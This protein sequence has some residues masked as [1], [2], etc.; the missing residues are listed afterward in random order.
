MST[1]MPPV[2]VFVCWSEENADW[3][4]SVD[5]ELAV[6]TAG[7][8]LQVESIVQ[9]CLDVPGHGLAEGTHD[10]YRK[11][12]VPVDL[13]AVCGEIRNMWPI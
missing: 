5:Y 9:A 1:S 7:A 4:N 8:G 11:Q 13:A 12:S 6:R 2:T 3:S 10:L